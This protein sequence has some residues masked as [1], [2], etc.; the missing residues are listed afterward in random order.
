[1][2]ILELHL[3]ALL[4]TGAVF[5]LAWPVGLYLRDASLVDLWWAPGIVLVA[6]IGVGAAE[7]LSTHA[8]LIAI[9]IT[10]WG[11]R[12]GWHLTSR[13]LSEGREDPRYT[14]MRESWGP[15]FWWKSL[16]VVSF[17]Q[18]IIQVALTSASLTTIVAPAVS[19]GGVGFC[20]IVLAIAGG[21]IE[22]A[23]DRQLAAHRKEAAPHALMTTGLYRLVRHPNYAGEMMFWWGL[24]LISADAGLYWTIYSPLLITFL[25]TSVSG[26]PMLEARLAASKPGYQSYRDG[27]PAFAPKLSSLAQLFSARR[28]PG[29]Q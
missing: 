8:L 14:E 27:T 12:L 23:A 1:M 19:F 13:R 3:A 21:V 24:W 16:F 18:A 4:C 2:G 9:L 29:D 11:V 7:G 15:A 28:L 10:V 20:G 26:A 5:A 6:W 17:L 22:A 25:L